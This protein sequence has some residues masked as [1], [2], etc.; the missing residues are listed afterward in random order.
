MHRRCRLLSRGEE[1]VKQSVNDEKTFCASCSE[2]IEAGQEKVV[3]GGQERHRRCFLKE[4]REQG[5]SETFAARGTC[6]N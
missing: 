1:S 4:Q 3:G 6:S 5:E 2:E